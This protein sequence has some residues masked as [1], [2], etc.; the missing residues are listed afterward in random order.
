MA[1]PVSADKLKVLT[2]NLHTY[3]ELR[4]ADHPTRQAFFDA[5][6]EIVDRV[7]D[8]IV[9]LDAD[10]ICL[11]EVAQLAE[12]PVMERHYGKTIRQYNMA[13]W[14]AQKLGKA[15]Q[16]PYHFFWDWSHY[17]WNIWEEGVAVISKY[18]LLQ[19]ESRYVSS[20]N[21]PD[22]THA[23]KIVFAQ[24][25][26]PGLGKVNVYSGHLDGWDD[27]FA[28]QMDSCKG[29]IRDKNRADV[30]ASILAGDFNTPAQGRGYAHLQDRKVDS[31][32][33][34]DCFAQVNPMQSTLSTCGD[35]GRIDYVLLR[36]DQPS[37]KTTSGQRVFTKER[38][39][40][41]SDH[42]GIFVT[43]EGNR[44]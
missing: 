28:T 15:K 22:N 2:V 34:L 31:A 35:C 33:Y 10:V 5:Y 19:T 32:S 9:A 23:R 3:Q 4:L 36:S 39:G 24:V 25:E 17:G 1:L 7:V 16:R 44:H 13:A 12:M 14:I 6:E 27:G 11:Q 29:W 18:P 43:L 26:I 20:D 40:L 8:G 37:L 41:V 38:L 30:T 42:C 21:R